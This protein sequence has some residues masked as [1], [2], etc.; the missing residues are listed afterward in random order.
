MRLCHHSLFYKSECSLSTSFHLRIAS[1]VFRQA[2]IH[3]RLE[4]RTWAP[5][6]DFVFCFCFEYQINFPL[7]YMKANR[8]KTQ[9]KVNMLIWGLKFGDEEK[10]KLRLPP[11]PVT[12][13]AS[14]TKRWGPFPFHL[15]MSQTC[16]LL[17]PTE[18]V[19]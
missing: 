13:A 5:D 12:R 16:Y 18:W 4:S 6:P 2:G 8:H 1:V 10:G 9:R 7:G 15:N 19:K 17:W 3:C 11:F 14:S